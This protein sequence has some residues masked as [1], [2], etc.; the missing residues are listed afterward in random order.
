[1]TNIWSFDQKQVYLQYNSIVVDMKRSIKFSINITEKRLNCSKK[2]IKQSES[3]Q[4]NEWLHVLVTSWL[5]VGLNMY[6]K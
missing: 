2:C 3:V 4:V 1:M 6:Y 5:K